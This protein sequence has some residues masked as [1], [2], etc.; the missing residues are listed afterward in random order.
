MF[1]KTHSKPLMVITSVESVWGK[2]LFGNFYFYTWYISAQFIYL[3]MSKCYFQNLTH[4]HQT[5]DQES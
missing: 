5:L 3:T 2:G 1:R 4:T